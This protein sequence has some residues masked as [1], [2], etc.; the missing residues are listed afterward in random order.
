MFLYCGKEGESRGVGWGEVVVGGGVKREEVRAK[1]PHR[2]IQRTSRQAERAEPGQD[3]VS[4]LQVG[5]VKCV[6]KDESG[7]DSSGWEKT[8]LGSKETRARLKTHKG[9]RVMESAGGGGFHFY[10]WPI[11]RR[12]NDIL[13]ICLLFCSL[14][15]LLHPA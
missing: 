15:I 10:V 14:P 4:T 13:H 9:K 11:V 6:G 1:A 5:E 2:H 8:G 7:M 12:N 3:M